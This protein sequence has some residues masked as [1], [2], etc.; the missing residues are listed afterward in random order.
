MA[1]KDNETTALAVDEASAKLAHA[2]LNIT[3]PAFLLPNIYVSSGYYMPTLLK[4][5]LEIDT[6]DLLTYSKQYGL[7][8]TK[9]LVKPWVSTLLYYFNVD[10][11]GLFHNDTGKTFLMAFQQID[12]EEIAPRQLVIFKNNEE[13]QILYRIAS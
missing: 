1:K 8:K 3:Q 11:L 13:S 4:K 7:M 10:A 6:L 9:A 2:A 5:Q 12:P